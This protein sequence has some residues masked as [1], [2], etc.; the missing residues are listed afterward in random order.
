[1]ISGGRV[2]NGCRIF[3][4]RFLVLLFCALIGGGL[5][6]FE[7]EGT[8]VTELRFGVLYL[9]LIFAADGARWK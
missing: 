2:F 4:C 9:G 6:I 7:Q 3:V 1:M 8:K 5:D